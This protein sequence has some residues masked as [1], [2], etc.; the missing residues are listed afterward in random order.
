MSK[1]TELVILGLI[2]IICIFGVNYAEKKWNPGGF[3]IHTIHSM[4]QVG[5]LVVLVITA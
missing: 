1:N 2:Q 3:W 4:Y 5:L